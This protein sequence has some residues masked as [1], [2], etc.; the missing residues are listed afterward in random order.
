MIVYD[1]NVWNEHLPIEGKIP[2]IVSSFNIFELE[3]S[4]GIYFKLVTFMMVMY[5]WLFIPSYNTSPNHCQYVIS[6]II[7]VVSP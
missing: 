5:V 6:I 1:F 7:Q 2:F 3:K 4:T